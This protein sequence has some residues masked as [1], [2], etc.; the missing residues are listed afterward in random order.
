[1]ISLPVSIDTH[2]RHVIMSTYRSSIELKRE[3]LGW[4]DSNV[5]SLSRVSMKL[6]FLKLIQSVCERNF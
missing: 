2:C 5:L 4:G 1:M 6:H 3:G